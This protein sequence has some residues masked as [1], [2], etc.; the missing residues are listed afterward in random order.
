MKKNP[1]F[2]LEMKNKEIKNRNVVITKKVYGVG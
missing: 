1:T 2:Y